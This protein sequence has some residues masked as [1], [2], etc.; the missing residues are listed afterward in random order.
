VVARLACAALGLLVWAAV[1]L[2]AAM[3]RA[4]S[5]AQQAVA[6]RA[7]RQRP[8]W[9]IMSAPLLEGNWLVTARI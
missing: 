4:A 5:G 2:V 8:E 1:A 3:V 7:P 9:A 6:S